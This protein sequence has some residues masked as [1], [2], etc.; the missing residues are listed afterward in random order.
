MCLGTSFR[1]GLPYSEYSLTTLMEDSDTFTA[2]T[3][4]INGLMRRIGQHTGDGQNVYSIP[5]STVLHSIKK[6]STHSQ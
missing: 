1:P 2:N 6:L 3:A 4:D 5:I